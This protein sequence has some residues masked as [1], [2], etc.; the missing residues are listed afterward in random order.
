VSGSY[1][2]AVVLWDPALGRRIGA[3]QPT[4]L[5]S[6][7]SFLPDGTTVIIPAIADG[8]VYRWDTRPV[9]WIDHAC[10]VAGRQF[11]QDEW[12]TI[13]GETPYRQTCPTG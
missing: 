10:A 1:D 8:E 7:P 3:I 11:T 4:A 9:A 6:N 5:L 13:F 2:G 12:T